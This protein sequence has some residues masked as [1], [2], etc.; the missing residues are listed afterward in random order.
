MRGAA[1]LRAR[2]QKGTTA[3]ALGEEQGEE[4]KE[5]DVLAALNFVS[6]GGQLLKLTRKG[7]ITETNVKHACGLIKDC[8]VM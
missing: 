7:N 1:T 8:D 3:M 4:G 6:K 2:L 5:L